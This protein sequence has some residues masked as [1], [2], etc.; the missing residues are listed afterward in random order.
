M[1]RI[2]AMTNEELN[3]V[4]VKVQFKTGASLF[5]KN[6]TFLFM[7]KDFINKALN[8]EMTLPLNPK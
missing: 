3:S 8:A 4:M 1:D 7:L 2:V 5:G 6:G